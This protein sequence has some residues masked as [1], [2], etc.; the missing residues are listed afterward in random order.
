MIIISSYGNFCYG[1]II[2]KKGGYTEFD[3][4]MYLIHGDIFRK[5]TKGSGWIL[6]SVVLE[7]E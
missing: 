7:D 3:C 4:M 6:R 5:A 2:T 1:D